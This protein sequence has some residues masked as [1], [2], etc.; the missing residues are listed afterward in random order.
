MYKFE[1]GRWKFTVPPDAHI[2]EARAQLY[3]FEQVLNLLQEQ[4]EIL[5]RIEA[6]TGGHIKEL[7]D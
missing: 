6:N 5:K 1:D 7:R 4:L 2:D 3:A